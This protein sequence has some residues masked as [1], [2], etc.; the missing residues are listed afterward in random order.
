MRDR[1]TDNFRFGFVLLALFFFVLCPGL[2]PQAKALTV[3]PVK[4]ELSGDP[5]KSVKGELQLINEQNATI[6]FYTTFADFAAQGE[7]GGANFV[8]SAG[9]LDDWISMPNQVSLDAGQHKKMPFTISIPADADPGGHFA[10]IFFGTAPP[11]THGNTQVSVGAKIGVLVLLKVSGT[12]KQGADIVEFSSINH[13]KI[14]STFP[15]T[16]AYRFQNSGGDRVMPTGEIKIKNIFGST[17]DVLP[18]NPIKGNVL[19]MSIRKFTVLCSQQNSP[20]DQA[21]N[22]SKG[23]FPAVKSQWHNFAF[24]IYTANLNLNYNNSSVTSTF[25]VFIFPWQLL[26]FIIILLLVAAYV[27]IKAVKR[28]NHWIINK[29]KS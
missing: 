22:D 27:L 20:L 3:S 25:S 17:V 26:L 9:E 29:A 4:V 24:G 2:V 21:A 23:F 8:Y 19:P 28:Y 14:F 5:G 16:F 11:E 15:V 7:N 1:L 10:A 6:T 12:V 18:A 13:Q